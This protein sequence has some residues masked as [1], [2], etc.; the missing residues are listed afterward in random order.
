MPGAADTFHATDALHYAFEAARKGAYARRWQSFGH[1]FAGAIHFQ[2]GD[3]GVW[4]MPTAPLGF[5]RAQPGS[6]TTTFHVFR[7]S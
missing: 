4:R 2:R 5:D 1:G 6:D 7:R 3:D